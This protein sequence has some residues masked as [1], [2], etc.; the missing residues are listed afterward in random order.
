[1]KKPSTALSKTTTLT[2]SSVSSAVMASWSCGIASGPKMFSGG[3][4]K[5]TRQ[6]PNVA[7][8]PRWQQWLRQTLPPLLVVWGRYDPSFEVAEAYRRDVPDTEVHVIDAGHFPLDQ[9]PDRVSQLTGRFLDARRGFVS[10]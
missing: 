6:N 7:N 4:S 8:Y 3:I 5:V 2:C 9:A 1:M 10:R